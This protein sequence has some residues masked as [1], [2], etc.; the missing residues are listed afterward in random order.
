MPRLNTKSAAAGFTIVEMMIVLAIA[1]LIL[2]IV[3]EAIPAL[4]RNSRNNQRK[5]DV[6]TVLA[7]VSHWELN[8]SGNVPNT[9]GDNFLQ[10]FTNKLSYYDP[11]SGVSV[12][13]LTPGQVAPNNPVNTAN[14]EKVHVY[15]YQKCSAIGTGGSTPQGAGYND[16]VA[17]Y[18]IET[19]K[20]T[21]A[22]QCQQL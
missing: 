17:I 6:Q 7:A 9:P 18:E 10:Y 11:V 15:N 21:F 16:V 22:A 3:F 5:Q 13:T 1:G 2:L 12:Q 19:G 14:L 4:E 20:G 8:H